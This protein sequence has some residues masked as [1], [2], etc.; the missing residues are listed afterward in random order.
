MGIDWFK[1]MLRTYGN[2]A[3][4]SITAAK[5]GAGAVTETKIGT[6]AVTATKIGTGAVTVGKIGEGAITDVKISDGAVTRTKLD[7]YSGIGATRRLRLQ[8]FKLGTLLQLAAAADGT[9]L[10]L[11][12][13]T[14]GSNGPRLIGSVAN[15]N[16]K[17]EYARITFVLPPEY[18]AGENI[19]IRLH[20]RVNG[21]AFVSQT[22]DVSVRK[23]DSEGGVGAD[24]CATAAQNLPAAWGNVDFT[25][26]GASLNPG[27][28]LDLLVTTVVNDTGGTLNK[29]A[30]IGSVILGCPETV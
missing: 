7:S 30:E 15:G 1:K 27:D 29:N 14:Y 13:G 3:D 17:T 12:A 16:S 21:S 19:T 24:I 11:A 8:D 25:I 18:Y 4:S 6:G 2:V 10:G 9:V 23:I 26:T 22:V 28:E 5:I 20:C